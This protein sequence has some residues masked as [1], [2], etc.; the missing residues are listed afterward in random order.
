M[1]EPD[2]A[3][4][5]HPVRTALDS[6]V[7]T[8]VDWGWRTG[9][10]PGEPATLPDRPTRRTPPAVSRPAAVLVLLGERQTGGADRAL[11]VLLG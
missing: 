8:G 7:R 11:D 3:G 9:P 5:P 6:L 10:V 1:T 4:P 2:G